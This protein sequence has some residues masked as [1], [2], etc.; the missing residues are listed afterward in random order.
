MEW[1]TQYTNVTVQQK[2]VVMQASMSFLYSRNKPWV[3]KGGNN[4]DIGMGAYHGAQ[5]CEVV[6][7]YI[8]S[9]LVKLPNFDAILY[10]DDGLGISSSAPRQLEKLKQSIIKVF[11]N[12]NLDITIEVGLSRVDYLDVTLDLERELHRPYRKPGDKPLYVKSWSNHPPGV[13]KNIPSGINRRL[14]EISSNKE[15]FLEAIPPYQDELDKCGYKDKL[16][17]MEEEEIQQKKKR[18]RSKKV[19]WF[20]PPY[21]VN[22]R[23]N[24]G[25]EFLNLL[26]NHFPK[27]NTLQEMLK[28]NTVKESYRC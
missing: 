26:D 6:G 20:N 24:V 17:W 18:T 5:A 25:K 14:C 8:L 3:K 2:K 9:K 11:N 23:T 15:V 7:L 1:A 22:I 10:R 21:S 12:H 27:R 4:F 28:Q 19:I 13:L 16:V